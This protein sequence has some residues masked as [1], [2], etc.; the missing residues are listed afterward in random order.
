MFGLLRLSVAQKVFCRPAA[1]YLC[2]V[3]CQLAQTKGAFAEQQA[4][5]CGEIQDK[6]KFVG[7]LLPNH[8]TT[9]PWGTDA[10]WL[11]ES[12]SHRGFSPVV[13]DALAQAANRFNGLPC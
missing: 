3:S 11:P 12:H 10:V 4:S 6:L 9:G 8:E 5:A 13:K 7:H 2:S 1:R